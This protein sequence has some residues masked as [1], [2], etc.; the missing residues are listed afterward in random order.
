MRIENGN[1]NLSKRQH[2]NQK[3]ENI[4]WLSMGFQHGEKN[5]PP[6]AGSS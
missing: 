2:P 5:P 4:I 1:W 6:E 3:V